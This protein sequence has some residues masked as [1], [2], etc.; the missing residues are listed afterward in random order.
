MFQIFFTV[1]LF[2]G[3]TFIPAQASTFQME[4]FF[5]NSERGDASQEEKDWTANVGGCAAFFVANTSGKTILASARHCF[6]HAITNW[7]RQNGRIRTNTG[8]QGNCTK[9][10]A[11]DARF[12]IAFFEADFETPPNPENVL[13]MASFV[14]PLYSRLIMVGYPGDKYR[15]GK[16]TT[17]S[18][19]WVLRENTSSPHSQM[20]DRSS[21]HNCSTYG[22]NSGGPMILEGTNVAIGLPFTYAPGDYRMRNPWAISSS[23][24][25]AQMADMVGRKRSELEEAGVIIVD[26]VPEETLYEDKP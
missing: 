1:S 20:V 23:S 26:E 7:C 25:L 8:K 6:G 10:V 17:T 5:S 15:R 2:M 13:R 14:P 9:I 21:L 12:D 24:H 11:A 3:L 18:N 4:Q 19:C 22:G 16:L